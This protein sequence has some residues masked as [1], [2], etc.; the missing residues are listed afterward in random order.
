MVHRRVGEEGNA[1]YG[2]LSDPVDVE[3]YSREEKH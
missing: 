1:S 3:L 2:F